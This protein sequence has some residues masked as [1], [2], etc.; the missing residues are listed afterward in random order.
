MSCSRALKSRAVVH[1]I[2]AAVLVVGTGGC[3]W[4]Q[5]W[6]D[7]EFC[8]SSWRPRNTRWLYRIESRVSDKVRYGYIDAT[9]TVIIPPL[10]CYAFDFS[11]DAASASFDSREVDIG[12]DG[13]IRTLPANLA[14]ERRTGAVRHH[15]SSWRNCVI[16]AQGRAITPRSLQDDSITW[17]GEMGLV[18]REI[19]TSFWYSEVYGY[20][21][22]SGRWIARPVYPEAHLP[23]DGLARVRAWGINKGRGGIWFAGPYGYID[24]RGK[25]AIP[26]RLWNAQD[27]S[28]GLAAV[29]IGGRW[30]YIDKRGEVAIRPQ[31]TRVDPFS[32]GLARVTVLT[33]RRDCRGN[34]EEAEGFI[35]R[36]GRFVIQPRVG[37][38]SGF[39][40]GLA[41]IEAPCADAA[42]SESRRGYMD[43][44]AKTVIPAR[45]KLASAFS[46][47][48]AAVGDAWKQGYIDQ[49]GAEVIPPQF[50][51][52]EEFQ[53]GVARVH[54]ES[55]R[56][57]YIDKTGK[58]IWQPPADPA[59]KPSPWP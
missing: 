9:G 11:D 10:F 16:D 15:H 33:A 3:A 54:W 13:V 20:V 37:H 12:P 34:R 39:N 43:K 41:I 22:R 51:W 30:G 47:G 49:T 46:E 5:S 42:G 55:N 56:W 28:E 6:N 2:A 50:R 58:V 17:A 59:S 52:A 18:G 53:G 31:F 14:D 57:G 38:L 25:L 8:P 19:G 7:G 26:A 32:E 21:D 27:F 36:T 48:L 45:Y 24:T 29:R 1:F 35:D 23:R 44:T 40:E 4:I